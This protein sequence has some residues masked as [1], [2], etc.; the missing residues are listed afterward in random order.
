MGALTAGRSHARRAALPPRRAAAPGPPL[1]RRPPRFGPPAP[2]ASTQVVWLHRTVLFRQ[3]AP[4]CP[5]TQDGMPARVRFTHHH[6]TRAPDTGELRDCGFRFLCRLTAE[7][8]TALTVATKAASPVEGA[9]GQGRAPCGPRRRHRARQR[10]Q[11][12]APAA[13][14]RRRPPRSAAAP[15]PHPPT[16]AEPSPASA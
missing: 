1:R 3:T 4:A 15:A 2:P 8:A 6:N 5:C 13:V 9:R 16:V 14:A 11:H 7:C 10:L 12:P